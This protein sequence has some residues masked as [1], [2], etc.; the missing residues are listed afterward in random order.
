VLERYRERGIHVL[1][2]L[3]C[4]AIRWA[5]VRPADAQ[6]QRQLQERYWMNQI[7]SGL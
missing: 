4:G 7:E 5:S 6:S 2:S 3:P 1:T